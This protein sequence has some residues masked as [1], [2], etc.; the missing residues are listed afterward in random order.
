MGRSS[1][2]F[3]SILSTVT[4]VGPSNKFNS[5]W[6]TSLICIAKV[7]PYIQLHIA[8]P[9]TRA[10]LYDQMS[11]N[12][13]LIPSAQKSNLLD[14]GCQ[15]GVNCNIPSVAIKQSIFTNFLHFWDTHVLFWQ[16]HRA[17]KF[18]FE[19]TEGKAQPRSTTLRQPPKY[20]PCSLQSR[21]QRLMTLASEAELWCL[22]LAPKRVYSLSDLTTVHNHLFELYFPQL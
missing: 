3:C 16:S 2:S 4:A 19:S 18:A 20:H 7:I 10:G 1:F 6:V 11:K 15:A 14:T 21:A 9:P 13:I 5:L 8:K 17:F 22:L 12:Y